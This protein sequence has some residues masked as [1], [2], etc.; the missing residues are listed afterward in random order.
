M[1]FLFSHPIWFSLARLPFRRQK[2]G[3]LPV[4]APV[5]GQAVLTHIPAGRR[6]MDYMGCEIIAL[7]NALHFLGRERP[8]AEL[9]Q[10]YERRRWLLLGGHLGANPYAAGTYAKENGLPCR[11]FSGPKSHA[12]FLKALQTPEDGVFLFSF[13]LGDTIFSG[14]HAVTVVRRN[15]QLWVYNLFNG[16]KAPL[17]VNDLR[18]LCL[19]H[20]FI[21][22]YAFR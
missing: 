12:D 15:G 9:I 6:T 4:Q 11:E 7:F 21:V 10:T 20:R 2:S 5:L 16:Q 13:W 14:A 1:R 18:Q 19:G 22:G 3:I 17:P 8:L